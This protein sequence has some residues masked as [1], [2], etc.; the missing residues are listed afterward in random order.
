MADYRSTT[1]VPVTL[2][3]V[4]GYLA[5]V[6]HLP[7]YLHRVRA[8]R[9]TGPEQV[10]TTATLPDGQTVEGDADWHV[11]DVRKRIAWGSGDYH[12]ELR[13]H[14]TADT[15][16]VTLHLHTPHEHDDEVQHGADAAME[17]IRLAVSHDPNAM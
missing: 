13:V 4:F 9:T 3:E 6:S 1:Y 17:Q 8:A 14:E 10:H 12:G 5:D 15:T 2:P 7:E 11:D 16:K